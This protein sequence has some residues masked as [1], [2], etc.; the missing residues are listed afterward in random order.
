MQQKLGVSEQDGGSTAD[1]EP[2]TAPPSKTRR[3]VEHLY[4][5]SSVNESV[6]RTVHETM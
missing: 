5:T 2:R 3:L 6:T 4:K 1:R